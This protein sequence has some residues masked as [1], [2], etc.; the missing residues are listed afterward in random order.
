MRQRNMRNQLIRSPRI[1]LARLRVDWRRVCEGRAVSRT[2]LRGKT[3]APLHWAMSANE[4]M[5]IR[6][7]YW[8]YP[9]FPSSNQLFMGITT[10]L[11]PVSFDS[12]TVPACL[13]Y[14]WYS[15]LTHSSNINGPNLD[16]SVD[17]TK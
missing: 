4:G 9:R 17:Y 5:G 2:P 1:T 16:K 15:I 12:T 13:Y 6:A 10:P 8:N 14:I 3:L 7:P 11:Y